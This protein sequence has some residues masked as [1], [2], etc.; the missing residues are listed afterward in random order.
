MVFLSDNSAL[1]PISKGITVDQEFPFRF[2]FD[3][4]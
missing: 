3:G 1:R 4:R 2:V